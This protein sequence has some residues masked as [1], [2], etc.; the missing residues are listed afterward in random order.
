MKIGIYA[1]ET[2]DK[3]LVFT[4]EIIN[5][6]NSKSI[7]AEI[8]KKNC[9]YDLILSIGG[10]GTFLSAA[11]MFFDR[12]IPIAGVNF[13]TLGYLSC[14]EKS[15][16]NLALDSIILGK[17]EIEERILLEANVYG[18]TIYGLN[19]IVVNRGYERI[20]NIR[21]KFDGRYVDDYNCDGII[22][23]T[24]TGSTAYSLSAGGP[25]AE[26]DIDV[27]I[28]TPVCSHSLYQRPI[29]VSSKREIEINSNDEHKFTVVAD[30]HTTLKE[31]EGVSIKKSDKT[32]KIIRLKNDF[33]F[34]T[35]RKKLM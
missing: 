35:V 19:E 26:P 17:Y 8:A 1:N 32:V 3:D 9:D 21:V 30:G 15:D 22:V 16:V 11:E 2:K 28:L 23:S 10:D 13:G 24:P 31:V 18:K 20:Q 25:I 33:F 34:D 6:L 7:T 12:D 27:L 5:T 4:K 29:I 14:I